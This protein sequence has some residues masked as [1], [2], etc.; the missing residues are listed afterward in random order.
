MAPAWNKSLQALF[1]DAERSVSR[2]AK[3]AV[4]AAVL[5]SV[6]TTASGQAEANPQ[7][8]QYAKMSETFVLTPTDSFVMRVDT[9]RFRRG[10]RSAPNAAAVPPSDKSRQPVPPEPARSSPSH[11]SHSS[12]ASHSSHRSGG[13]L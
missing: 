13:W 12:H 9:A 6:P 7:P 5:G 1:S 8:G 3:L 11:S 2:V 4:G 10:T